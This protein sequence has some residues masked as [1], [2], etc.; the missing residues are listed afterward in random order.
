MRVSG[1]S[2][3]SSD[4]TVLVASMLSVTNVLLTTR[5]FNTS[6]LL[7]N[8]QYSTIYVYIETYKYVSCHKA[9]TGHL[10]YFEIEKSL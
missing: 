6:V 1:V 7:A 9:F 10:S 5:C 3:D 8:L 4:V 2:K